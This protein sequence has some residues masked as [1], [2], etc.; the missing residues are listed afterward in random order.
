MEYAK[1][2]GRGE[3]MSET[4][5]KVEHLGKKERKLLLKAL[6]FDI[7]NLVCEL[8]G[9]KI[10]YERCGIMQPLKTSKNKATILCESIFCLTEYLTIV[11]E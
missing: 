6:D 7:K 2:R 10:G 11:E 9:E 4:E 8:C 3:K 1:R 5:M